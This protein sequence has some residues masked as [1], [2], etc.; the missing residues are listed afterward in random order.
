MKIYIL[1]LS[2]LMLGFPAS[3]KIHLEPY[4]GG[5]LVFFSD[6]DLPKGDELQ[7]IKEDVIDQATDA[8]TNKASDLIA[9]AIS[10]TEDKKNQNL[11]VKIPSY[12]SGYI[13]GMRVGY[14]SL[15]L[16]I[17]GDL[18]FGHWKSSG[19]TL[20]MTIPGIFVSYKLPLLF[21][22]YGTLIPMTSSRMTIGDSTNKTSQMNCSVSRGAKVGMSYLSLPL[23]SI[24]FE[25]QALFRSDGNEYCKKSTY[26]I[27]AF[28]NMTF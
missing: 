11:A 3:A 19:S 18:A 26:A 15:G 7:K 14:R 17:G 10:G 13:G 20:Q 5:S 16:G 2:F 21:R 8:I 4:F 27:S 22:V 1:A 9:D 6:K 25:S 23:L 24:N 28:I 12:A